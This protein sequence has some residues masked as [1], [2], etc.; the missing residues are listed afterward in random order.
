MF[1]MYYKTRLKFNILDVCGWPAAFKEA[2]SIDENRLVRL[3]QKV[4]NRPK[5]GGARIG[6]KSKNEKSNILRQY[7]AK[8]YIPTWIW[9]MSA[10]ILP[11]ILDEY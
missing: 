11:Y 8:C 5:A 2:I 7:K 9:Q 3:R 10:P 4:A 1:E 6:P